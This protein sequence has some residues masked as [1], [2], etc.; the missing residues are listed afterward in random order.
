MEKIN[1]KFIT[2]TEGVG[3]KGNDGQKLKG[4]STESL[5]FYFSKM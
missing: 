4:V 5:I 2:L 1:M 3:K